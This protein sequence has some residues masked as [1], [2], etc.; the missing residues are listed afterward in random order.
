MFFVRRERSCSNQSASSRSRSATSGIIYKGALPSHSHFHL[1]IISDVYIMNAFNDF[2]DTFDYD[3][4]QPNTQP[5]RGGFLDV[6]D[7]DDDDGSSVQVLPPPPPP[8]AP[9]PKKRG[10]GSSDQVLFPFVIF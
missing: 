6:D 2:L 8:A 7:D 10:G 5:T 3:D 1:S 4:T 9:A